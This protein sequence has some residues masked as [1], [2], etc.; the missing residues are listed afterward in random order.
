MI[1]EDPNATGTMPLEQAGR[2]LVGAAGEEP[3][4]RDVFTGFRADT[5][6]LFLNIDRDA[7]H[8]MGVSVAEVINALQVF[9]GSLYV[10]DFNLF[11]RTWQ[12]NVQADE[13]FRKK[14][15][16]L[17]RL[18]VKSARIE[19]DNLI[20]AQRREPHARWPRRRKTRWCPWPG[21][22]P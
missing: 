22:F 12:V 3:E 20:A 18:R 10:N 9:F 16:D 8:S 14:I 6:W 21:S 5:P 4:L 2:G 15:A 11:G 17:K 7:A 13:R 19:Q 1:V